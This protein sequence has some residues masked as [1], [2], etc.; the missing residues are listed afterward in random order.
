MALENDYN[1]ISRETQDFSKRWGVESAPMSYVP[2]A[3]ANEIIREDFLVSQVHSTHVSII[4]KL[5]QFR[6]IYFDLFPVF[7]F[8]EDLAAGWFMAI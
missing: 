8:P 5:V 6:A 7:S 1:D 3:L 4:I 2:Q